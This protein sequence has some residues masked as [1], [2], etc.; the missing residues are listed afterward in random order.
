MNSDLSFGDRLRWHRER[1][2]KSRTVLGGLV[3]RSEEWV[4]AVESG[5]IQMPRLPMLL[6]I[7][8]ALGIQDLSE[9]A[10]RQELAVAAMTKNAHGDL[11][12]IRDALVSH[13]LARA[14]QPPD[15][16]ALAQRAAHGWAQWHSRPDHRTA[17]APLLPD[18]IRDSQLAVR[19][20]EDRRRALVLLAKVHSLAQAWVAYQP[21]PELVWLAADRALSAAFEADDPGAI[22]GAAWY[23]AQVY[24]QGGQPDKAVEVALDS[25]SLLPGLGTE[26][27]DELR[28]CF[29]LVHLAASWAYAQ[30]GHE[31]EAWREWDIA[32]QAVRTLPD[33]YVHPWLMFGRAVVD[34]YATLIDTELFHGARAVDRANQLDL[35]AIP[36]RT[37]RAVH[38]MNAGRAYQLRRE[39]LAT[40][41]LIGQA[42]RYSP[43]TVRY[44]PWAR[45]VVL[46]YMH[47][48]GRA[49][50]NA[51]REM[52][53]LVGALD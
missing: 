38:A 9:L 3:G 26:V 45:Q 33:G 6:R 19:Y 44:R 42:H 5:R 37:R 15:L 17:T 20:S 25:A 31:G 34:N 28:A 10:G 8:E 30:A 41:H 13:R 47:S 18:L 40:L 23:A 32:D 4:K 12:R 16:E 11:D 51:A 39:P 50:Q 29:G 43:E 2:G 7:A 35:N 48:G 36:S 14:V 27:D 52:A 22:A 21:G 49:V 1:A 53:T 24:Q 46:E